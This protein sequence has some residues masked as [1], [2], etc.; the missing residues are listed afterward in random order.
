MPLVPINFRMAL[1]SMGRLLTKTPF[2]GGAYSKGGAYWEEGAKL[3]HYGNL[4]SV[5][6]GPLEKLWGTGGG[7]DFRAAGIF[8]RYQIPCMNFF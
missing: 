1:I 4:T 8:F 6:D 2:E 5:R 3:Y 7:R